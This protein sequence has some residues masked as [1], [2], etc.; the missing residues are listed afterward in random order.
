MFGSGVR[1]VRQTSLEPDWGI[2]QVRWWALT[3]DKAERE[4]MSELGAGH[5]WLL[6]L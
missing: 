5:V 1:H 4:D 2:G 6:F 3:Q